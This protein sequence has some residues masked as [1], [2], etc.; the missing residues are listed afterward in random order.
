MFLSTIDKLADTVQEILSRLVRWIQV[1][2]ALNPV[3]P[4]HNCIFMIKLCLQNV[5]LKIIF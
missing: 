2:L 1:L 4:L 3:D 5:L